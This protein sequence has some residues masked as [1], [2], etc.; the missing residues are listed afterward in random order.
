[1]SS[2]NTS[3]EE[4]NVV[5]VG[6]YIRANIR[7]YGMLIALVAIMVFFQFYTGGILFRPVN[8][9]NLILQNSF[10]VIMSLG[11]LL[12]I[13]AG[14]ID[15]SVG[16]IVAFV[17]AIAA[18][19]TVQWGMNPLLAALI[20]L[21]V[22]GLIGAAQ[23]YWIAYHRIP[24]FIVTLAG[25]LVFRGLTLFVLGGKNIGPFPV[26][27]QVVS[28]G[29]LPDFGGIEGFNT[30]S[31]V[32]TLAIVIAL[33]VLGLRRRQVNVHHG[34]DVEPFGFFIVQNL[35]IAGAILFLGYQLS[36][37]RGLPNVL[38]VMLVLIAL[39]SFVTRRTTIGR[40]IY[41]MGGNEKATKLSGINTE[42]LSFL[43]FVNMGVLAG[44]A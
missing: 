16:S 17:G 14:H 1:M 12:V 2:A 40:R 13:V 38:I 11:M 43:T 22:G 8:L 19:L 36:T 28:T 9:T 39:Y 25:M 4:S 34:I 24:S 31:M 29:F 30:T 32:L 3:T 21:G 5:S 26:D 6:S 27:F 7:E 41:A 33:F 37:Y 23:G 44:L 35:L 10:I 42:R 15:L 18:I 20:C